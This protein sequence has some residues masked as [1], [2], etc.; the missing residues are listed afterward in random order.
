M[1]WSSRWVIVVWGPAAS[2][3][4]FKVAYSEIWDWHPDG[5][6]MAWQRVG[7][8]LLGKSWTLVEQF[9]R[10]AIQHEEEERQEAEAKGEPTEPIVRSPVLEEVPSFSPYRTGRT[11][12]LQQLAARHFSQRLSSEATVVA[13]ASLPEEVKGEISRWISVNTYNSARKAFPE[14]LTASGLQ[15]LAAPPRFSTQPTE[16]TST[17]S[18]LQAQLIY[19]FRLCKGFQVNA[20][21]AASKEIPDVTVDCAYWIECQQSEHVQIA[22]GGELGFCLDNEFDMN[23]SY[24]HDLFIRPEEHVP[25]SL[26]WVTFTKDDLR[27]PYRMHFDRWESLEL[28]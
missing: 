21:K 11:L 2:V 19:D 6:C 10:E 13:L 25:A 27:M 8:N 1:G 16:S 23:L 9:E 4:R 12:P 28:E 14:L 17:P 3:E 22:G 18:E 5:D 20:L 26:G 15:S 7:Y 24:S